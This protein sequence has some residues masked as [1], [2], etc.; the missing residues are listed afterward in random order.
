MSKLLTFPRLSKTH[1]V[2]TYN[3]V[4]SVLQ[5]ENTVSK[6]GNQY[7]RRCQQH[8]YNAG[9][10]YRKTKPMRYY[11]SNIYVSFLLLHFSK[12]CCCLVSAYS[13]ASCKWEQLQCSNYISVPSASRTLLF[14]KG[15]FWIF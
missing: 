8:I 9:A 3:V 1:F 5:S 10:L 11:S 7:N 15:K 4:V 14:C 13:S 2:I 6:S 12:I